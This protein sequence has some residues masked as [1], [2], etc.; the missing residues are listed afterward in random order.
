MADW[1]RAT[2]SSP[3]P[4]CGRKR[5]CGTS[6]DG[7]V[8]ICMWVQ[9]DRPTSNNG[10]LHRL[11]SPL[12][13]E[14]HR[15]RLPDVPIRHAQERRAPSVD[16]EGLQAAY[17]A[18]LDESKLNVFAEHMGLVPASLSKLGIGSMPDGVYSFPM[19]DA[20]GAVC[21]IRLRRTSGRP[22]SVRG[23]TNGLFLSAVSA[24]AK[25]A[26]EGPGPAFVCEGES[27]TAAMLGLGLEA[28]GVPGAGQ[29]VDML[30]VHLRRRDVVVMV[31]RDGAGRRGA[32][33][34]AAALLRVCRSVRLLYPR[35]GK[36]VRE[37]FKLSHPT[38]AAVLAAARARR[39]Y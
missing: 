39:C 22:W 14:P 24:Q 38:A 37:W 2:K 11:T 4:I 27:D 13:S 19:R 16:F 6:A 17:Y 26:P 31:D 32:D 10:W 21:G 25:T 5:Y 30:K 8:A 20:T 9:S 12:S 29:C 1:L 23:S 28:V 3:C 33:R 18:Q 34:I 36:D 7:E 35:R 15:R